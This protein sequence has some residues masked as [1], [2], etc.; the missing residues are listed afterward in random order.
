MTG[1]PV[2]ATWISLITHLNYKCGFPLE[3]KFASHL[4]LTTSA[5]VGLS[6]DSLSFMPPQELLQV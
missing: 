4:F 6:P 3:K 1:G 5:D 2:T